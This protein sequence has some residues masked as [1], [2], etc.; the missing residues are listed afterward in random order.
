MRYYNCSLC[1][2]D[3]LQG[4]PNLHYERV[5]ISIAHPNRTHTY[6]HNCVFHVVYLWFS[7]CEN[8][9]IPPH[10]NGTRALHAVSLAWKKMHIEKTCCKQGQETR[11]RES[12]AIIGLSAFS[13]GSSETSAFSM[14]Y[15]RETCACGTLISRLQC[16]QD[17]KVC[18]YWWNVLWI[19]TYM[20]TYTF[21]KLTFFVLSRLQKSWA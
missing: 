13:K 12:A 10:N 6:T 8:N 16:G 19:Y 11:E 9:I 20:Y 7:V 14:V 21:T 3:K 2:P 4:K 18:Y 5:L 17:Y 15:E 1:L